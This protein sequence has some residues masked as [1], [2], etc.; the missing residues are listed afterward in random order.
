MRQMS[1]VQSPKSKVRSPRSEV[2]E[3]WRRCGEIRG[4]GG[5]ARRVLPVLGDD[6]GAQDLD[7]PRT[8]MQ[9]R[10]DLFALAG[11]ARLGPCEFSTNQN[12]TLSLLSA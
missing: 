11:L 8:A 9:P 10:Q 6:L 4:G 12:T 3:G 2:C 5:L 1:K 7:G